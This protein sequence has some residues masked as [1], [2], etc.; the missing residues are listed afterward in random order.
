MRQILILLLLQGVLNVANAQ[1]IV[2]DPL[3]YA[4]I[5]LVL[6]EGIEQTNS[7][8][9]S[10]TLLKSAKDNI[11]KV[12]SLVKALEDIERIATLSE[13]LLTNSTN[14]VNRLRSLQGISPSELNK[15]LAESMNYSKRITRT[16][17]MMTDLLTDNRYK[18]NDYERISLFK[19]Q[20][21]E[22]EMIASM[23]ENQSR[24]V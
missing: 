7:L 10:L 19:Q 17:I 2:N 24:R 3:N 21:R 14:L 8:K 5:G 13:S 23:I 4:Q 20:L 1:F 9:S 22:L 18:V 15:L 12:S 16:V 11:D 6:K